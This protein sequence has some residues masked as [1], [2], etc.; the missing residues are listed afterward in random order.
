[1]DCEIHSVPTQS[2]DSPPAATNA[3]KTS[4]GAVIGWL[5]L[6]GVIAALV[7]NVI[8]YQ[9]TGMLPFT[10]HAMTSTTTI[11]NFVPNTDTIV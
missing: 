1:M 4:A 11:M 6:I 7:A 3:D 2:T 8:H 10:S 9:K 5:L